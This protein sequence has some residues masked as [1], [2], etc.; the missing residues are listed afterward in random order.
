MGVP[1]CVSDWNIS[2]TNG[3]NIYMARDVNFMRTIDC[4]AVCLRKSLPVINIQL[5][6][7]RREPH[8]ALLWANA[9]EERSHLNV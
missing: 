8:E 3:I 5:H 7:Y 9:V 2:Y 1:V 4:L 6:S